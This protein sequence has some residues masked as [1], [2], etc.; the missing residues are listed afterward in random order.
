LGLI[1]KVNLLEMIR[2]KDKVFLDGSN[3]KIY[4]EASFRSVP[5]INYEIWLLRTYFSEC[6][7]LYTFGMILIP[8]E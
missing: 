6:L 3:K 7:T 5:D 2:M 4:I 1:E 8:K